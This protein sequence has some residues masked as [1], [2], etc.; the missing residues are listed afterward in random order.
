MNAENTADAISLN[1]ITG[2]LDGARGDNSV[3]AFAPSADQR[4]RTP[5][6]R[7]VVRQTVTAKPIRFE[8]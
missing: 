4:R 3:V 8:K 5:L 6:A 2:G 1:A 7:L